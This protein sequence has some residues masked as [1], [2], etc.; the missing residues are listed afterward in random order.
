MDKEHRQQFNRIKCKTGNTSGILV[1]SWCGEI[2]D[3]ENNA[4]H[5]NMN[6]PFMWEHQDNNWYHDCKSKRKVGNGF[7]YG[8]AVA[9][10]EHERNKNERMA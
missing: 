6:H 7:A 1:C 9:P 2:L 10:E 8:K 4:W 3:R 5:N